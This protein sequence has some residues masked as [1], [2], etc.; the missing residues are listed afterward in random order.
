VKHHLLLLADY[1]S[2]RSSVIAE[3]LLALCEK[4]VDEIVIN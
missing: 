3:E 1:E 2:G 4:K